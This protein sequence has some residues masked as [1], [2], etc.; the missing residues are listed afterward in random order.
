MNAKLE[1][2]WIASKS[3]HAALALTFA[4][5]GKKNALVGCCH[6]GPLRVQRAFYPEGALVPHVYLLHPPGGV[7]AGDELRV[8]VNV[9]PHSHGLVTTPSAGRIY[10]TNNA[11][12]LQ[13]Q[14]LTATV[15]D[16]GVLEWL[17]QENIIFNGANGVNHAEFHL[18]DKARL[19]AWDIC[20]L[21]RPAGDQLF[22]SG[23]FVQSVAIYQQHK[24]ALRERTIFRGS[25]QSEMLHAKWGLQGFT[26]YGTMIMTWRNAE[27]LAALKSQ[28][29][30]SDPYYLAFT[31]KNEFLIA[32]YLG[33]STIQAR[34]LFS[35]VWHSVRPFMLAYMAHL[36]K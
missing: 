35:Q 33:H 25:E 23:Q 1:P 8:S 2:D 18:Q 26:V 24:L 20:C 17:P 9:Q 14:Q 6:R 31:Q 15:A 5:R 13:S 3:W 16:A 7:V 10:R 34:T 28:W 36:T 4:N 11:G 27:S 19:V 30:C 32:R 12:L 22:T 21:G 29:Q